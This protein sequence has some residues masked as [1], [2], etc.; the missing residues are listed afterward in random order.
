MTGGQNPGAPGQQGRMRQRA[1]FETTNSQ[2]ST[3]REKA[4]HQQELI[5]ARKIRRKGNRVTPKGKFAF[6]IE[7]VR[8]IAEQA[9]V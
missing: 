8:E 6:S 4:E 7:E 5:S 2:L 9:Q 1:L 3:L